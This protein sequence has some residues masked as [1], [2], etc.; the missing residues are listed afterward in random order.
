MVKLDQPVPES[1]IVDTI[2]SV[3]SRI[4]YAPE[5]GRALHIT[6][7]DASSRKTEYASSRKTELN[8]DL[9]SIFGIPKSLIIDA[10]YISNLR[11]NFLREFKHS[12]DIE[13]HFLWDFINV[14]LWPDGQRSMSS[15]SYHFGISGSFSDNYEHM[16]ITELA[17]PLARSLAF[18]TS[19]K[20]PAIVSKAVETI[21]K[22]HAPYG[23]SPPTESSP[24]EELMKHAQ[25]AA[26]VPLVLGIHDVGAAIHQHDWLLAFE[27]AASTGGAVIVIVS[28]VAVAQI[29]VRWLAMKA[30]R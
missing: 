29:V 6:T 14:L 19:R 3:A 1:Q 20:P 4:L 15:P 13:A 9:A 12:R 25:Y 11:K 16:G 21:L 28:S 10:E 17:L 22:Y 23:L 8:H 5:L 2:A 7:L 26:V 24:I 18:A 30:N 27:T